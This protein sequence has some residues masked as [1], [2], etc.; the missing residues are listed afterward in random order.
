VDEARQLAIVCADQPAIQPNQQ[1]HEPTKE[2]PDRNDD[3]HDVFESEELETRTN[4]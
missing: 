1:S 2:H 4:R 3:S